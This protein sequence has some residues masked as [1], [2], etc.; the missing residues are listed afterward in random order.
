MEKTAFVYHPDTVLHNAGPMHPER[1]DRVRAIVTHLEGT[2]LLNDLLRIEP[3]PADEAWITRVHPPEYVRLIEKAASEAPAALDADTR[4]SKESFRVARL[5]VGGA[6]AAVDAVMEGKAKN[7]FPAVRPPGHHASAARAMG[8]CLL[9]NIAVAARC[10]QDKYGLKRVLIVDWDVHH[11]NGTQDIFYADPSV[12]YF[13]TH[14]YPHYPGT[15]SEG[16]TGEGPGK[17]FTVN[18]PLPAGAGDEEVI[19]AFREK[20]VPAAGKFQPEFVL[21]SAGFDGHERDPLAGLRL[22]EVGFAELTRIVMEIAGKSAKGRVVSLLEGGY[23]LEGL[24]RSVEA[25]L[26]AL[27]GL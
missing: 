8:F 4:V 12:L 24:S 15:G 10:V 2:G 13:S 17:G 16:E 1:P 26:R 14:Q 18:A 22:T 19:Q 11:G 21:I 6:L 20:L 23:D 9:N 7:A 27:A 5:A 25:H 3:G